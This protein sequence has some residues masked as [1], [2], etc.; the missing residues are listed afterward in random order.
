[1]LYAFSKS[2]PP[3]A[4]TRARARHRGIRQV[5][6][7]FATLDRKSVRAVSHA[8]KHASRRER[9]RLESVLSLCGGKSLKETAASLDVSLASVS[10]WVARF[11]ARGLAGLA[12]KKT[13]VRTRKTK[14]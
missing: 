11:K 6:H 8:L 7:L 14:A 3:A 4:A 9:L 2:S 1:M 5:Q 12:D 13:R 10:L